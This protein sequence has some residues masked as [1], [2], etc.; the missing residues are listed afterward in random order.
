MIAWMNGDLRQ[1]QALVLSRPADNP[2][3]HRV[4]KLTT[5]PRYNSRMALMKVR[6]ADHSRGLAA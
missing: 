3:P 5:T 6:Y 4:R 2:K 1:L